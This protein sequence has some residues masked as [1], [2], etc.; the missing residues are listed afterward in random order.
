MVSEYVR[1]SNADDDGNVRCVTCYK[2][3][4]WQES[5]AGHF[6]SGRSGENLWD[7]RG[8][9]P[10]CVRCNVF[11]HGNQAEYFR[12]M[13]DKYGLEVIDELRAQKKKIKKYTEMDYEVMIWNYQKLLS[14]L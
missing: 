4:P 3:L 13:F 5:Q 10:Q 7:L 1:R 12:F 2:V 11:F 6:L 14:E 9:H 8:I